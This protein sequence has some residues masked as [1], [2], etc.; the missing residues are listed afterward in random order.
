M[1]IEIILLFIALIP[2]IFFYFYPN[3]IER[4]LKDRNGGELVANVFQSHGVKQVFTLIGGH[5]SSILVACNK[6]NIKVVD[7]RHEVNTVFA[8]DAISRLTKIPGVAIVTA[9]PGVTNTVTALQ[10]ALMSESPLILIGGA[11]A[12]LLKGR[13]ALQDIEQISLMKTVCKRVY[14]CNQVKKIVP[15]LKDAFKIAQTHPMGP[16]FV[17]LPIDTLYPY[18]TVLKEAGISNNKKQNLFTKIVNTYVKFQVDYVFDNAFVK[19]ENYKPLIPRKLLSIPNNKIIQTSK[20]LSNSKKPLLVIGSQITQDKDRIQDSINYIKKMSIPCYLTGGARGL[21]GK[22][23]ELQYFHNRTPALKEADVILLM[24]VT[25]DFRMGYGKKLNKKAKII[26][27]NH[28][29]KNLNLNHGIFWNSTIKLNGDIPNFLERLSEDYQ[30]KNDGWTQILSEREEKRNTEIDN[31]AL[32]QYSNN[33]NPI[34]LL[35]KL[36]NVLEDNSILVADGGDFVGTAAYILKPNLLG[37]LDPGPFGTLGV[38]AGFALGA[39]LAF[40]EKNVWIIYG[41]GA[42]GYSLIEYDTFKRHKIDVNCII[43]NDACWSQIERDQLPRFNDNI[44]CPLLYTNYQNTIKS[45]NS[46]IEPQLLSNNQDI[47]NFIINFK[48]ENVN[49]INALISKTDF[50]EGSISV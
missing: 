45:I 24:G 32:K 21:L 4:S 31:L 25:C 10:N 49:V 1:Y 46:E 35:K 43:G 23:S 14:S 28:N 19:E 50:R 40:P 27:V 17:E 33:L 29:Y 30:F 8:A 39:K 48:K 18:E 16:V 9:G 13:G 37:W 34:H 22:N 15:I 26:A 7:V 47:N 11:S 38:G 6:L 44:A 36:S 5:I 3:V 20:I 42:S 41:D 12:T 2:I